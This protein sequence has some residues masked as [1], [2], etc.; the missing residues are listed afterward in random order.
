MMAFDI[1]A[2]FVIY[3]CAFCHGYIANSYGPIGYLIALI[4][5][6]VMQRVVLCGSANPLPHIIKL[7]ECPNSC[8]VRVSAL[9]KICQSLTVV[10]VKN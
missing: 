9:G 4:S 6:G 3:G 5:V 7:I 8:E 1:T 10:N 2:A